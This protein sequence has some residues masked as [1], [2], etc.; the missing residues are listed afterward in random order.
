MYRIPPGTCTKCFLNKIDTL[1]QIVDTLI[2]HNFFIVTSYD[3]EDELSTLVKII[4]YQ[5]LNIQGLVL[6]FEPESKKIPYFI[7]LT[8]KY[9]GFPLN[10]S[11]NEFII[12]EYFKQFFI[13]IKERES[14]L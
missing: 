6:P 3:N 1:S 14:I 7:Q 13:E 4:P 12:E 11:A 9:V 2:N 10:Y 5:F 8:D